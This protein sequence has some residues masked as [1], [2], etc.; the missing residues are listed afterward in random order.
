MKD[1]KANKLEKLL[2]GGFLAGTFVGTGLIWIGDNYH[3]T[4]ALYS[5]VA[6]A[7]IA[8]VSGLLGATCYRATEDALIDNHYD[9][10]KSLKQEEN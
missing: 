1:N 9:R 5:G 2:L 7:G 4:P 8:I 10:R 3:S 6:V